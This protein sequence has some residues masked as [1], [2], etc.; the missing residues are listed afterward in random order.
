MT[1]QALRWLFA[2]VIVALL[3]MGAAVLYSAGARKFMTKQQAREHLYERA[4][5][6]LDA[7]DDEVRATI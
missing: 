1:D 5:D 2:G 4:A 7:I 3:F 6:V